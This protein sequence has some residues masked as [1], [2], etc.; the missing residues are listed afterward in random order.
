MFV[1]STI[2]EA[3]LNLISSLKSMDSNRGV[4]TPDYLYHGCKTL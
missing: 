2:G 4:C 1:I 3:N